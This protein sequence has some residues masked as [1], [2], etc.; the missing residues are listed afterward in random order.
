M[1]GDATIEIRLRFVNGGAICEEWWMYDDHRDR[2]L[3]SK[4][5]VP[6]AE[7]R[8][9]FTALGDFWLELYAKEAERLKSMA[10]K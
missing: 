10:A 5:V 2:E 4:S 1:T 9:Y 6:S 8:E 7:L 3:K